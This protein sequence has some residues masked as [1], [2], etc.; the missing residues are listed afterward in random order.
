MERQQ[1]SY[2]R[3]LELADRN[4]LLTKQRKFVP[5]WQRPIPDNPYE[6]QQETHVLSSGI[7]QQMVKYAHDFNFFQFCR[8][9]EIEL[10]SRWYEQVRFRR[11]E[12]LGFPSSEI[13][14]V[15]T[16]SDFSP[17]PNI[18][19][20]FLGLYGVDAAMPAHFLNDIA[21]H[22]EGWE[23]WAHFLDIFNHVVS[24]MYYRAWRKYRY[25]ANFIAGGRDEISQML[26][27][28]IGCSRQQSE[29]NTAVISE[30]RLL[31]LLGIFQQRTRTADGLESIVRYVLP[32]AQVQVDEFVP[33][34]VNLND[35][36]QLGKSK[37][38]LNGSDIVLG[39]RVRDANH[40]VSITIMPCDVNQFIRVLP[41]GD[42]F[43]SL[44]FLLSHYL[45]YRSDA[46]IWLKAKKKWLVNSRLNG[47]AQ[48]G[49][50][51]ALGQVKIDQ[52]IRLAYYTRAKSARAELII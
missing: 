4:V 49:F 19:T 7:R 17:Y 8:L 9:L 18:Y 40:S 6:N 31:G 20:T 3:I 50:T 43:Q 24:Q 26:L 2:R 33:Q 34:W 51:S 1:S 36:F 12:S 37:A 29:S 16:T 21:L 14:H 45:G 42:A 25:A 47:S 46:E 27:H 15:E 38:F 39:K 44:M 41:N 32:N 13:Y 35:F 23:T 10:G 28:F 5:T 11:R 48:L 22:K 30:V 52:L